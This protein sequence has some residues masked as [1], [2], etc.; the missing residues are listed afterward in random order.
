MRLLDKAACLLISVLV[1]HTR[2]PA[3]VRLFAGTSPDFK[4]GLLVARISRPLRRTVDAECTAER[5]QARRGGNRNAFKHGLFS[6]G[7]ALPCGA[8][9]GLWE[10]N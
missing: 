8:L 5:H 7:T 4:V 2:K 1:G 3:S 9:G 6:T 10:C